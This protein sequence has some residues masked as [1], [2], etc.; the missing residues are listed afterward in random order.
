[1]GW[2]LVA[3]GHENGSQNPEKEKKKQHQDLVSWAL[4]LLSP[5]NTIFVPLATWNGTSGVSRT[6]NALCTGEH[7]VSSSV[8]GLGKT[9][10]QGPSKVQTFFSM[11]GAV[12]QEPKGHPKQKMLQIPN[13][14]HYGRQIPTSAKHLWDAPA[15]TAVRIQRVK[16]VL[17][18]RLSQA[19]L[20]SLLLAKKNLSI[21]LFLNSCCAEH[22]VCP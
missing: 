3:K 14:G 10:K 21:F 19:R 2:S 6:D 7:Q 1:M 18:D 15:I 4:L 13:K 8:C 11:G 17:E 22:N 5:I 20:G 12:L 9:S 16:E